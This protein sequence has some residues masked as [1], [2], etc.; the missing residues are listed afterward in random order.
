MT[1]QTY[2]LPAGRI[3][4]IK[5]E[6]LAIAEPVEVLSIGCSMKPFPKNKGDTMIY[7]A[8]IPTGGSTANANSINRWNVNAAAHQVQ[9]GVTPPAEALNYRDV[10]VVIQQYACLYSYTDKA[11]DISEDDIPKDQMEQTAERMGLVREMIRYGVMKAS[12]T[13]QY[14][15]GLTR[16]TV[17][18]TISYNMLS[19]MSRTLKGNHGKMKTQILA[20]G[21]A[22]DTSAIEASYIVFVHTDAEH[23]IRRLEDFVPLAKY[24]GRKPISPFEFGSMN[25][26]RF[27]TSPE[28]GAYLD[29]GATVAAA[30]LYSTTGTNIDVY[31]FIVC[32]EECVND[33]A[34]NANFKVMHIPAAQESK[35]DPLA[36]RGY[37]GAKFWSAAVVTNPGWIGVIEAGVTNLT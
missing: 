19:L 2:G 23:D 15:G 9:E 34:L 4:K 29:A 30:G 6:M 12:S 32:A 7:R 27:I 26:Y 36:Q 35:E 33:V 18:S 22:Y 20:A 11:A 10:T 14:A 37:V 28:L 24:A 25:N 1:I 5:G 13:V 21:P 16:A 8:R 3:N 31:P 17:S